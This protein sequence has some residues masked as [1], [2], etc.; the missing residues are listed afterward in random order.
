MI[1]PTIVYRTPGDHFASK[2]TYSYKG[3]SDEAELSHALANGW[4]PSLLEA[5]AGEHEEVVDNSAPTREELADKASELG[6]KFDGR[7]TDKAL[8]EKIEA[9]LAGQ[10]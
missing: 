8:S 3:V 10:E 4:F 2:G 7:T 1:F 6:I 5:M 9:A